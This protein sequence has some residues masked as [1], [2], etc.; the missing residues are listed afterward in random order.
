MQLT[1]TDF[2]MFSING[3]TSG[4]GSV[5]GIGSS[6]GYVG[7]YSNHGFSFITN[8]TVRA[9]ITSGGNVLIGT[10]TND[11]AKLKVNGGLTIGTT[12]QLASYGITIN[13]GST[14][15]IAALSSGTGDANFYSS[16]TT[17]GYHIYGESSTAKF[18]VVNGGQIYSTST[19]I[20]AISDV[21]HKENIRDL[22]TGLSEILALKPSRFDW[23]KGKGTDKKNVAGF[24]AQD[25][26]S[27][28]PDLVDDWKET[29]SSNETY[30][31]IRMTDLIPT[32][33]K[34]I[35]EQQAQIEE[36]KA[37]INK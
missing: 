30:K 19:S 36:L 25:I 4:I 35:Q 5:L 14:G 15:S 28:M 7:T 29:M 26:E 22:E 32:L 9:T 34:A 8:D 20:S 1:G 31:S 33:V 24:I 10:T 2:P 23:K 12:G 27:I 3:S 13:S 11:G 17:I 21:R 37:L 16:S 6:S 18:Y